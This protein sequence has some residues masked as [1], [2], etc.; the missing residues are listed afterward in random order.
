MVELWQL[1]L[2]GNLNN[3]TCHM[4]VDEES[5]YCHINTSK[6]L[7]WYVE[8]PNSRVFQEVLFSELLQ[9]EIL[10]FG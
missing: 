1:G 6:I 7:K 8:L 2:C 9:P 4:S 10:A 3:M 5:A